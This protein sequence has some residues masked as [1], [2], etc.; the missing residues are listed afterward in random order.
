MRALRPLVAAVVVV[1]AA[2][3]RAQDVAGIKAFSKYDFVPG[4]KVV[5][6]HDF[7]GDAVG[8]FPAGWNTNAS[9]EVVTISGKPGHWLMLTK[10]GVFAPTLSAAL[11]D[12]FT[13]EYDLIGS[14]TS[15]RLSTVIAALS[16]LRAIAAWQLADNR[17]TM[18]ADPTGETSTERRQDGT[19]DANSA[20]AEAFAAK[21]GGVVH[22]SVWRQKERVRV[23]FNDQKVW[24]VPKALLP[25]ATFNSILFYVH[26]VGAD[27]RYYLTNVRLAVGAPDTRNKLVTEGKFVT[28][29]ILFDVNSDKIRG[30]SY[31][32]LKDIAAV[33]KE[34]ADLKVKIVGHTDADGD[35]KAN[36]DLSRR[37]AA[38]VRAM[39]TSEFGI[40]A[41]RMQT[42]GLG[43]SQPVDRNDNAAGKANNRRV[44]FIKL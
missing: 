35:D 2:V 6:L 24:D 28:H 27:D 19:V 42:D 17:F 43:E 33:L 25:T 21:N 31:G 14:P 38:S 4:A 40:D 39:L 30:E 20:Q 23:Y 16:D 44:E 12:N 10:G 36:L 18:N 13:L 5:A 41:T 26:D 9:G 7:L 15:E 11:P 1:T 34:N 3:V 29:G 37:R 22:M 8:D 32:T